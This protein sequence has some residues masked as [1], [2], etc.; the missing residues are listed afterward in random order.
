MSATCIK[1]TIIIMN[2]A[3]LDATE[4]FRLQKLMLHHYT[5]MAA[6]EGL[7]DKDL[8][9]TMREELKM[10]EREEKY[11]ECALVRDVIKIWEDLNG[12]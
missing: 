3:S 6:A 2:Y 12:E 4:K 7:T 8:E 1:A 11:E 9:L 5:Q 10:F